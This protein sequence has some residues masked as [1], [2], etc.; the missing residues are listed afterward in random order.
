MNKIKLIV[1]IKIINSNSIYIKRDI[2]LHIE[3][4]S[5]FLSGSIQRV[6]ALKSFVIMSDINDECSKKSYKMK[7]YYH[8]KI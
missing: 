2:L 8:I 1:F 7:K 6:F 5:H 4:S 3:L